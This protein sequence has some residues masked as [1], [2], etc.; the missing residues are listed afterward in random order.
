MGRNVV[1]ED[2]ICKFFFDMKKIIYIEKNSEGRIIYPNDIGTLNRYLQILGSNIKSKDQIYNA[3]SKTW[4]KKTVKEV[5]KNNEKITIE[6]FED[7]T[8]MKEE[9]YS[10]KIDGLTKLLR[11]RKESDKLIYEYISYATEKNENF[12]M[13]MADIDSFKT[14]NDTYGHLCGDLVLRK[15]GELLLNSTRQSNDKFNYE[16]SDIVVRIGGDEFLIL[17]KNIDLDDTKKKLKQLDQNVKKLH[18]KYGGNYIPVSMSF[19]Y[20]HISNGNNI[21]S[22]SIDQLKDAMSKTADDFLYLNK[23]KKIKNKSDKGLN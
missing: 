21:S 3:D 14:I 5:I 2:E 22:V 8:D 1:T 20:A 13:V 7:I 12:S 18:I 6:F 4:Y 10:S 16:C 11:D 15:V 9:V 19:G 17:L 23:K